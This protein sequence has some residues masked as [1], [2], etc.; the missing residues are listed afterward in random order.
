MIALPAIKRLMLAT[1]LLFA[2]IALAATYWAV[3]GRDGILLRDD[4]PR[5][6]EALARIHRG[7]IYDRQE[8]LLVES[9]ATEGGMRRSYLRPSTY[10]LVGYYSLRYG[11]SGVE[12]ASYDALVGSKSTETLE[13]YFLREI[14][15][16]P[17]EGADL[18]LTLAADVQDALTLAMR[19][20]R[21]AAVVM[22]SKSGAIMAMASLPGYDPN[23]L[24]EDWADLV[25]DEGRPFFNRAVQG[26]YQPGSALTTLWLAQAIQSGYD[27]STPFVEPDAPVELEPDLTF[28]CL[29]QPS[30]EEITLME[31]F[32]SGCPAPFVNY[33]A[34][35]AG[36]SYARIIETFALA[37]PITLA[38]FPIPGAG[39]IAAT[40]RDEAA[41]SGA[42]RPRDVLGQ[43]DLTMT[44]LQMAS[45]MSAIAG[46]GAAPTPYVLSGIRQPDAEIWEEEQPGQSARVMM[47]PDTAAGLRAVFQE[48]WHKLRAESRP[49]DPR[50]GANIAVSRSGEETQIWLNGFVRPDERPA[51]AFVAVL[52]NTDDIEAL[53]S[54][55]QNLAQA[56]LSL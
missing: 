6:I 42:L 9:V 27:L 4:N 14:L 7:S 39:A 8:Q 25:A 22:D 11:A 26:L 48:A 23:T 45:I 35:Q 2:A 43:G 50:V 54:V 5:L 1:L 15:N 28:K 10:S 20:Y 33:Q 36:D 51:V 21:G 17:R 31:A 12:A 16:M 49:P 13:N 46:D 56:I 41:E 18:R 19:D 53:V 32:I 29:L 24:D 30:S 34:T 38:G 52:E 47:A 40:D 55:G 37:E 3:V 44:P